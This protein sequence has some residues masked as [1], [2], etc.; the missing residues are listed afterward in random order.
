MS[1]HTCWVCTHVNAYSP[2]ETDVKQCLPL[3]AFFNSIDVGAYLLGMHPPHLSCLSLHLQ[4]TSVHTFWACTYVIQAPPPCPELT[5]MHTCWVCT[6]ID[7]DLLPPQKMRLGRGRMDTQHKHR[8]GHNNPA[9]GRT[10]A[11]QGMPS[12]IKR[13]SRQSGPAD[14][15]EGR[16]TNVPFNVGAY[17]FT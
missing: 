2:A 15:T 10:S 13:A 8:S 5:P 4:S 11:A 16:H 1:V 6:D 7:L 14:R 3:Q 12:H 9:N 17:I